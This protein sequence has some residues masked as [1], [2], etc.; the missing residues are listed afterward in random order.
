MGVFGDTARTALEKALEAYKAVVQLEAVVERIE[1]AA[2]AFENRL[3]HRQDAHERAT[4][5][6]VER[7]EARIRELEGRVA[8]L[9]GKVDGALSEAVKVVLLEPGMKKKLAEQILPQLQDEPSARPRGS[10]RSR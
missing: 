8:S 4:A 7:L 9:G 6:K 3:S 5:D 10:K 1:R 2:T